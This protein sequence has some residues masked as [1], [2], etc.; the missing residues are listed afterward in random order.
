MIV[1]SMVNLLKILSSFRVFP[2]LCSL[3]IGMTM[4]YILPKRGHHPTRPPLIELAQKEV[5][6]HTKKGL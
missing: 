4:M 3:S 5:L 6:F 2:C 1:L